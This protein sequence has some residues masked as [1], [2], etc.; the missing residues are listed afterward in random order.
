MC[1]LR[2][3]GVSEPYRDGPTNSE[4]YFSFISANIL[5]ICSTLLLR[6]TLRFTSS[7][8]VRT[9][10]N[11]SKASSGPPGMNAEGVFPARSRSP[12][13][14]GPPPTDEDIDPSRQAFLALADQE[15]DVSLDVE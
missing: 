10:T 5:F 4:S 6:R 3:S 15:E 7:P 8:S 14:R 12:C 2:S 13:R 11:S 1:L 9:L